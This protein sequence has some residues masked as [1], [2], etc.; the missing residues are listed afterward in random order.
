M[1]VHFRVHVYANFQSYKTAT[2]VLLDQ[3]GE[4][5]DFGFD[6]EEQYAQDVQSGAKK[7]SLFRH[8]KMVLHNQKVM[9]VHVN[10]RIQQ[11]TCTCFYIVFLLRN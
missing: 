3:Y 5:V 6:A 4:F 1:Y 10:T 2:S 8:F 7:M 11:C 9:R